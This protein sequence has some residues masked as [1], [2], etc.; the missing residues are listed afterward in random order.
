MH[1]E[2]LAYQK[3]YLALE[4]NHYQTSWLAKKK[5]PPLQ[6]PTNNQPGCP[7]QIEK[8]TGQVFYFSKKPAGS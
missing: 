2:P 4:R 1:D 5:F 3:K 7:G 6:G 8:I